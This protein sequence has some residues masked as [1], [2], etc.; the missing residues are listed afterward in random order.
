[1]LSYAKTIAMVGEDKYVF[2]IRKQCRMKL[3]LSTDCVQSG[4]NLYYVMGFCWRLNPFISAFLFEWGWPTTMW[5]LNVASSL[6][7]LLAVHDAVKQG[8]RFFLHGQD[9]E[10]ILLR[11]NRP[12]S[13]F[14]VQVRFSPSRE[15]LQKSRFLLSSELQK[16]RI[17]NDDRVDNRH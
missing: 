13:T 4:H 9:H 14:T 6:S 8:H 2:G 3:V 7:G 15:T 12:K 11:V 10:I 5:Y 16:H 1:M 17:S